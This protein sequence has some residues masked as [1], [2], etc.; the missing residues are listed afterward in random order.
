[1][2]R[3]YREAALNRLVDMAYENPAKS[4]GEVF[5]EWRDELLNYQDKKLA[6]HRAALEANQQRY[7]LTLGETF[8]YTDAGGKEVG[9]YPPVLQVYF[10][11]SQ[12]SEVTKKHRLSVK[13]L[14]QVIKGEIFDHEGWRGLH[15]RGLSN[16]AYIPKNVDKL[17]MHA[18]IKQE[19]REIRAH[20]AKHRPYVAAQPRKV[21]VFE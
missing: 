21:E 4:A 2:Y 14:H 15:E 20:A 1:M 12:V 9:E 5:A 7:G 13:V 18:Q 3:M 17:E 19:D 16:G 11:E 8:V 6:A 10:T